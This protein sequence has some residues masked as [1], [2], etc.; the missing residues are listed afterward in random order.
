MAE[1]DTAKQDLR[2]LLGDGA[3]PQKQIP[4]RFEKFL[5]LAAYYGK[6]ELIELLDGRVGVDAVGK[7]IDFITCHS[8]TYA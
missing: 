4:G 8:V 3:N 6:L 7:A 5:Q 2:K 1:A